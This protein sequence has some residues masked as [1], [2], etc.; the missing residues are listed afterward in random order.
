M[1]AEPDTKGCSGF[2]LFLLVVCFHI[3][4]LGFVLFFYYIYMSD[5]YVQLW[6]QSSNN[7]KC[8][9]SNHFFYK[10]SLNFYS[11]LETCK[12]LKSLWFIGLNFFLLIVLKVESDS[13]AISVATIRFIKL[14]WLH[15]YLILGT[16]TIKEKILWMLI[17]ILL[18]A[19]N[20]NRSYY[21][22]RV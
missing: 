1:R 15:C 3:R 21:I 14:H 22:C 6:R 18:K 9:V 20:L 19:I 13:G 11:L 12:R 16:S 8:E 17:Y 2:V 5:I 7:W 10:I 4:V